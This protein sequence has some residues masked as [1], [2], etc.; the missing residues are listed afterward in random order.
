M[1][2]CDNGTEY[3]VLRQECA[4][5]TLSAVKNVTVNHATV[6]GRK[7]HNSVDDKR[8]NPDVEDNLHIEEEEDL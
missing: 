2:R 4:S 1:K 7:Y 3:R 6:L 5:V 8:H